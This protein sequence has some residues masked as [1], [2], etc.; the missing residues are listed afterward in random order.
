LMRGMVRVQLT[1]ADNPSHLEFVNPV[2]EG[3]TRAAQ[4]NRKAAGT[5]VQNVSVALPV[6]LHGDAA[7]PGEGVVSE[8]LN[9]SRLDGYQT[10]GT[11]HIIANNQIGFTTAAEEGRSTLYAS[12]LAKGFEIPVVHVNADDPESC[13]AVVRMAQAYRSRFHK[14][15]L[16]DLVGYRRWGHNEGDEPSFTQPRMYALIASHPSVCTLYAKQLGEE[17][18]IA[19]RD[20]ESMRAEALRQLRAAREALSSSQADDSLLAPEPVASVQPTAVSAGQ[21]RAYNA[22]LLERPEGFAPHSRLERTLKRE[23]RRLKRRVESS[24]PLP[25]CWPLP[26][27]WLMVCRYD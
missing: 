19:A 26:R 4:E 22:A 7:F 18:I 15:F 23:A 9:L 27:F 10:G 6:L 12:D 20:V 1:L 2:V 16:I 13:L 5:P 21:L 14:D 25:R 17:G 3:F 8:T 24:G 11:V